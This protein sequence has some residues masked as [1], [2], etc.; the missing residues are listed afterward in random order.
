MELKGKDAFG[1]DVGV[2]FDVVDGFDSVDIKLM[3]VALAADDVGVPAVFFEEVFE[4]AGACVAIGKFST[5]VFVVE[6]APIALTD[7]CL[8]ADD[9]FA[10][11]KRAVLDAAVDEAGFVVAADTE[12]AA[13]LEVAVFLGGAEECVA[14]YFVLAV[15]RNNCSIND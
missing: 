7:V 13:E 3:V 10:L 1:W 5:A 2:L 8:V 14:W 4:G 9:F 11:N 15:T 12:K 6:A